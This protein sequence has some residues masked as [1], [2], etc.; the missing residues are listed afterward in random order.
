MSWSFLAGRPLWPF[1]FTSLAL[2]L[3]AGVQLGLAG[4]AGYDLI[5]AIFGRHYFI[6]YDIIGVATLWQLSRQRFK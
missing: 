4:V 5:G 2:I 3:L 1:D 6:V